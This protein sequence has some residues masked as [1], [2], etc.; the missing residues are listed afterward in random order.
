MSRSEIH[1][2]FVQMRCEHAHHGCE[3]RCTQVST[4]NISY[5][6]EFH[7]GLWDRQCLEVTSC[8]QK[9]PMGNHLNA[10]LGCASLNCDPRVHSSW[11]GTSQMSAEQ[12]DMPQ[13]W[14]ASHPLGVATGGQR[15][16][17]TTAS[18]CNRERF[19]L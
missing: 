5:S 18:M 14:G 13:G 15:E 19:C 11:R 6:W 12:G 17:K 10:A 9:H 8:W 16:T 7:E 1:V 2:C 4:N 3:V